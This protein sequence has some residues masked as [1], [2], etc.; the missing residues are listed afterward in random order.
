MVCLTFSVLLL[1]AG[2]DLSVLACLEFPTVYDGVLTTPS[3]STRKVPV[4]Q[5]ALPPGPLQAPALPTIAAAAGLLRPLA[6][7][8]WTGSRAAAGPAAQ[9]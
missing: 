5:G 1:L 8:M 9:M 3:A 2:F 7:L 4:S 6:A